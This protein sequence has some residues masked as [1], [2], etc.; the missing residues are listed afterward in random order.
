MQVKTVTGIVA[1]LL[2]AAVPLSRFG[3]AEEA[4]QTANAESAPAP[5]EMAQKGKV[6][7]AQHCSHCHGFNMVNPGTVTYDLRKFPHDQKERFFT[8]VLLGKNGRMP[9]WGDVLNAD[10]MEELWA[11]VETGGAR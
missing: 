10:D 3:R 11:Y 4:A 7:Y 8:S 6:L 1:A 9:A 5:A 2:I